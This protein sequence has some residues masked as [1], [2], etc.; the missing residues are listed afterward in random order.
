MNVPAIGYS[1]FMAHQ[2][3]YLHSAVDKTY[4]DYQSALLND[5]KNKGKQLTLGGDGRCDS[6]GHPAK[7]GNY[8]LMDLEENK[9]L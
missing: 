5:I 9:I 6:P 4:K 3:K 8:T 7:Y 2:K 1:T